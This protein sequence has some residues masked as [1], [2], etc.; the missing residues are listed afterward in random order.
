MVYQGTMVTF[1]P[2]TLTGG[3]FSFECSPV[4]AIGYY[5]EL[6]LM[7]APFCQGAIEATLTGVTNSGLDPSIEMINHSW[8][9]T[10]R[11]AVGASAAAHLKLT[12]TKRGVCPDGGGEVTFSSTPSLSLFPIER[13]LFG[14]LYRFV[15]NAFVCVCACV[16]CISIHSVLWM[17]MIVEQR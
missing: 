12:V 9:P 11:V 8:L 13:L 14:K 17:S 3:S 15:V 6:L 7:L 5:V 4:R 2:G 1:R 16:F 10:Y